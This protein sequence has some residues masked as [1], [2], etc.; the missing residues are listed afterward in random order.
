MRVNASIALQ[1]YQAIRFI[2]FV[3]NH[4]IT[5]TRIQTKKDDAAILTRN[6]F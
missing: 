2:F 1:R 6:P 5:T 3:S 4:D